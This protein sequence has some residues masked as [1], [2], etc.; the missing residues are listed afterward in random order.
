[1]TITKNSFGKRVQE[2]RK[3]RRL[4]QEQLAELIDIDVKHMSKIECGR[5]FPSIEI[6]NKIA[7]ALEKPIQ[8]FFIDDHF[9]ERD[10]LIDNLV[11]KL[12]NLPENKFIAVYRILDETL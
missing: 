8:D 7:E 9:Q 4:T 5:H 10:V 1:M 2:L 3:A 11:Q 12:K 6:L